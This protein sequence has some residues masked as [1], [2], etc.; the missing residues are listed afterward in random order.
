MPLEIPTL[1]ELVELNDRTLA[2]ALGQE[3]KPTAKRTIERA[4][5][6]A[7]AATSY[8]LWQWIRQAWSQL[9]PDS[10]R[11]RWLD[12]L[13]RIWGLT[14][15]PPVA[16][17]GTL[18]VAGAE[19]A[20]LPIGTSFELDDGVVVETV[21]LVAI[22]FGQAKVEVRAVEPGKGGNRP[23]GAVARLVESVVGIEAEA[24]VGESGL[25]GGLELE[26]DEDLRPRLLLRIAEPPKGGAPA[27]YRLWALAVPGITRAWCVPQYA[28]PG[29]VLV[30]VVDDQADPITPTPEKLAEVEAYL[31]GDEGV[32]PATDT[33]MV[34]APGTVAIDVS[35]GLAPNT[36]AVRA[37]VQAELLAF[38]RRREPSAT[39][40]RSQLSDAI[41][42]AAGEDHHALLEPALDIVIP[43]HHIPVLGDLTFADLP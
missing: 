36:E 31:K 21:E 13:A 15:K 39:V 33:V 2:Q 19:G 29:T 10:A 17:E 40:Y 23:S 34:G 1:P 14:R 16:A 35:V 11:G 3:H 24:I 9:W 4:L 26:R 43:A 27:D 22:A 42:D 32:A 28:G 38:F 6:Y 37:A 20:E 12:R 7:W 18:L 30:L 5:A 8:L 41:S 25:V